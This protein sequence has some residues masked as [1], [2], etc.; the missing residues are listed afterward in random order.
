MKKQIE[1]AKKQ[2]ERGYFIDELDL[3]L[4]DNPKY[5]ADEREVIIDSIYE[6]LSQYS[7]YN[8]TAKKGKKK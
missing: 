8:T 1:Q 6:F 3:W 2:I 4:L 5:S 7:I